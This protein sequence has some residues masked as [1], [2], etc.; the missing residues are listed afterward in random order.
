MV[1]Y[2]WGHLVISDKIFFFFLILRHI[3]F[4]LMLPLISISVSEM[5]EKG[6]WG[7]RTCIEPIDLHD[8]T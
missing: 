1:Q 4:F 5:K 6:E 3:H 2:H 7:S 8:M